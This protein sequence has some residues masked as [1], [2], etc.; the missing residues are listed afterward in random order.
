ML[1]ILS[2]PPRKQN[3]RRRLNNLS[4]SVEGHQPVTKRKKSLKENLKLVHYIVNTIRSETCLHSFIDQSKNN[5][6]VLHSWC[7]QI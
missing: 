7:N 2:S 5:S 1:I 6:R 4:V 3:E